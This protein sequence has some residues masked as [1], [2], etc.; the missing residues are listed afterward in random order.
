M[1]E[2]RLSPRHRELINVASAQVS[3]KVGLHRGNLINP[4]PKRQPPHRLHIGLSLVTMLVMLAN[5]RGSHPDKDLPRVPS[6]RGPF[7]SGGTLKQEIEGSTDLVLT[8][9]PIT[10]AERGQ[11]LVTRG[12]RLLQIATAVTAVVPCYHLESIRNPLNFSSQTLAS[13]LLGKI[14]KWNDRAIQTLNP[15]VHLP[16]TDI[17][18]I[19]HLT[20]DGSTYTWTDFL[21]KTSANW[22][23][24]IGRVRSLPTLPVVARGGTPEEIARLIKSTPNSIS[25]IEL[26]AAKGEG[27]QIGRARNASGR[28]IDPSPASASAA[29]VTASS[30]IGDD[31]SASITNMRGPNDYP[32]ASFTWAIIPNTFGDRKRQLAI[33]SFL[34]WALT[35]G[36]DSLEALN[37]GRLP[38]VIA[39]REVQLL[40]SSP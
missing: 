4:Q 40:D 31:F 38:R 28:F 9:I 32:I 33:T 23:R 5:L 15:A 26:W 2:A 19:G 24:S 25:Y 30:Q 16:A 21:S 27:I 14:T 34:K 12:V 11:A 10:D 3:D 22:Q 37:F 39:Q 1:C 6:S 35:Q 18:V 20:E 17:L 8:D 13:I 7:N 36:Q 29:A